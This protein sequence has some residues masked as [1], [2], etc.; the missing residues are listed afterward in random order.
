LEI[1]VQDSTPALVAVFESNDR[2]TLSL[3]KGS[4]ED[5]GIPFW[6]QGDE[7]A[8]HLALIPVIFPSC[9][10]LVTKDREAEARELLAS[11]QSSRVE[12]KQHLAGE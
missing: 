12:K 1:E 3:A 2:F 6:M 10:L 9:R 7:T 4:L 11:L 8:A 5:A